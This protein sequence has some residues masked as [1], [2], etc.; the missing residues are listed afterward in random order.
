MFRTS[1]IAAALTVAAGIAQA[2]PL[3]G[4]SSGTFDSISSCT[5]PNTCQTANG[6]TVLRWGDSDTSNS[7]GLTN[8]STLTAGS[9]NINTS[10]SGQI[11]IGQL[12]WFNSATLS[13]RTDDDFKFDW[14]LNLAFNSPVGLNKTYEFNLR[15]QNTENS[16]NNPPDMIFTLPVLT[17]QTLTIGDYMLS[18]FSYS[19][20]G[21]NT[22]LTTVYGEDCFLIWCTPNNDVL[23]Y[24]WIN[25]E[26][27]TAQLNIYATV[28]APTTPPAEV[29]V[30]APLALIGLGALGLGLGARKRRD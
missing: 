27:K 7:N 21:A 8:P 25:G 3:T 6:G 29:P 18:N 19:V 5:S 10:S 23:G 13:S 28:T 14:N 1:F 17:G 4:T 22:Q 11:L 24:K 16:S 15:I 26:N 20:S 9:F 30:P 2:A 12:T